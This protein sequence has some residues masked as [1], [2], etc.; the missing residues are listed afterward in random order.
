MPL[1]VKRDRILAMRKVVWPCRRKLHENQRTY[2]VASKDLHVIDIATE[3]VVTLS[4]ACAY[5]PPRRRGR[6]VHT[7]TIWRWAH[8]GLRGHRLEVIKIGGHTCTSLEA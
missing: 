1:A 5:L 3:T 4:D 8:S 2:T 6:M 7:S